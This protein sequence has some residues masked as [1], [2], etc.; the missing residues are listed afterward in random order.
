MTGIKLTLRIIGSMFCVALI[1]FGIIGGILP[2]F[3]GEAVIHLLAAAVPIGIGMI[4]LNGIW[5][6]DNA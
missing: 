3:R 5:G 4:I 1:L 2:V 6:Q